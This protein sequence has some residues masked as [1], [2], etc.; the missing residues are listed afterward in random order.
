MTGQSSAP[1]PIRALV[2]VAEKV[3]HTRVARRIILS[4][5]AL[6]GVVGIVLLGLSVYSLTQGL[7]PVS[8]DRASTVRIATINFLVAE[9]TDFLEVPECETA[10]D[11]TVTCSGQTVNGE[12][13]K[14][15]SSGET[16]EIVEI[17]VGDRVVYSGPVDALLEA[18]ADGTETVTP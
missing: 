10:E 12:A 3:P 5:V 18:A 8:G 9:D 6:L 11:W 2:E 17:R 15:G 4:A 13:L 14:A 16:P 7:A 1:W